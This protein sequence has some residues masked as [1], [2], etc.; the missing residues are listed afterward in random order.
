MSTEPGPSPPSLNLLLFQHLE[1][2]E[3][4]EGIRITFH[5][6]NFSRAQLFWKG[7]ERRMLFNDKQEIFGNEIFRSK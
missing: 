1:I 5:E 2:V 3:F 4:Q 6:S 7:R